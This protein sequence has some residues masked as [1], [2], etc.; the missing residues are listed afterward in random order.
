MKTISSDQTGRNLRIDNLLF[1]R[2]SKGEFVIPVETLRTSDFSTLP[3]STVIVIDWRGSH[4]RSTSDLIC[5][6][7]LTVVNNATMSVEA[8]HHR[9]NCCWEHALDYKKYCLIADHLFAS[10]ST[11]LNSYQY[12]GIEQDKVGRVWHLFTL[13]VKNGVF[14]DIER[15]VVDFAMPVLQ[16]L[17]DH[18]DSLDALTMKQFGV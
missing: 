2:N 18:R 9:C 10:A 11:N 14:E 15:E 4:G 12:G 17:L 16:P 13:D 7:S 6:R 3:G 1:R 8:D 5:I